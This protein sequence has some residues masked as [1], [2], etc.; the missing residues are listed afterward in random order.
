MNPSPESS[1]REPYTDA[2]FL[3]PVLCGH[4]KCYVFDNLTNAFDQSFN[5][6]LCQNF[7]WEHKSVEITTYIPY[8]SSYNTHLTYPFYNYV[9]I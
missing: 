6:Y 4:F 7:P 1:G 5:L 9:F 8:H 2:V 3:T